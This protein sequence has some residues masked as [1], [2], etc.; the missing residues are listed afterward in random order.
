MFKKYDIKRVCIS[1]NNQSFLSY[2]FDKIYLGP[3]GSFQAGQFMPQGDYKID[4]GIMLLSK[5]IYFFKGVSIF[6]RFLLCF[7]VLY[8][9]ND[10]IS[11]FFI[12]MR[13]PK[14]LP[15]WPRLT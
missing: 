9:F 10:Q 1:T 3:Y 15:K 13:K 8:F 5:E 14:W 12:T 2:V 4:V 11:L 7:I 6:S